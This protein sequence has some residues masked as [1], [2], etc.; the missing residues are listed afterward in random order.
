MSITS[1]LTHCSWT[2]FPPGACQGQWSLAAQ[3]PRNYASGI[4]WCWF[5]M[6]SPP[7]A[8]RAPL[9]TEALFD[10][11][12]LLEEKAILQFHKHWNFINLEILTNIWRGKCF[13]AVK[14]LLL[15]EESLRYN[16]ILCHMHSSRENPW[17]PEL[18]DAQW[19]H[20]LVLPPLKPFFGGREGHVSCVTY[21]FLD[22]IP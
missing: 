5:R 4:S 2:I 15:H 13:H 20:F 16:Y 9:R 19:F 3:M 22:S 18:A 12:E 6:W 14:S 21:L 10:A 1:E 8:R 7:A 17:A 11:H